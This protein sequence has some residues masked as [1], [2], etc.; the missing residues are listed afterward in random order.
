MNRGKAK[1]LWC[2]ADL[3]AI[4]R[5]EIDQLYQR[6]KEGIK[7]KDKLALFSDQKRVLDEY[8]ERMETKAHRC[9]EDI[10]KGLP[11]GD[12]DMESDNIDITD[13]QMN[14]LRKDY[15]KGNK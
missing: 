5:W 12:Y 4:V 11:E 1:H 2:N 7:D 14:E 13:I 9:F 6:G 8:Y 3:Y 15:Y 10:I